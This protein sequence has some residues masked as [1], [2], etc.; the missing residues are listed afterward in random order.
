MIRCSACGAFQPSGTATCGNCGTLLPVESPPAY[1][2]MPASGKAQDELSNDVAC[3]KWENLSQTAESAVLDRVE[4]TCAVCGARVVTRPGDRTCSNCGF[5][6]VAASVRDTKRPL[7]Q[8]EAKPVSRSLVPLERTTLAPARGSSATVIGHERVS[9]P[10]GA[11]T[12][13]SEGLIAHESDKLADELRDPDWA[14]VLALVLLVCDLIMIPLALGW[15]GLI[16][17]FLL[18]CV[19]SWLFGGFGTRAFLG[20]LGLPFRALTQLFRRLITGGHDPKD[21]VR[22]LEYHLVDWEGAFDVFRVKGDV[23]RTFHQSDRVR[24]WA[25]QRNRCYYFVRGAILRGNEWMPVVRTEQSNQ[26]RYRGWIWL[27]SALALN[28]AAVWAYLTYFGQ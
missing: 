21:T 6:L 13:F 12:L 5:E 23:D 10:N 18:L 25:R 15:T 24:I 8:D 9:S 17:V 28:I 20:L 14:M 4:I 22:V 27:M 16:V 3:P 11:G 1:A 2:P 19:L 7:A 26:Q